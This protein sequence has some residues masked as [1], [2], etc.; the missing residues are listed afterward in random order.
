MAKTIYIYDDARHA[1]L[2]ELKQASGYKYLLGFVVDGSEHYA[3]HLAARAQEAAP[4]KE[5]DHLLVWQGK[6]FRFCPNCGKCN[7]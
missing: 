2:M 1:R 6:R 7:E 5:R 3:A 4:A